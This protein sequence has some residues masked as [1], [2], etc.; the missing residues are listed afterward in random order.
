MYNW[1]H[2]LLVA[3]RK[4]GALR[5]GA[6]FQQLPDCFK[7][8]QQRLLATKGGHRHMVDIL[9]LVLHH[10]PALVEQAIEEALQSGYASKEHVINCLHRKLQ[11]P[12]PDPVPVG[13]HLQLTVEPISD[14][15]RYE[16]LRSGHAH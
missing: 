8:L 1:R 16:Q 11:A 13:A 15:G 3:Q 2:Y 5:N 6:P 9:S 4:P 12:P 7:Q 14:T 10:E